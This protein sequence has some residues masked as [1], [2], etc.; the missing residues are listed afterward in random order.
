MI[1]DILAPVVPVF[2]CKETVRRLWDYLDRELAP[3]DMA[4]I[5]SHLAQC[6]KC[7][8]HF[9]FERQFLAAV[10]AARSQHT[11][12]DALRARVRAT[13][14]LAPSKKDDGAHG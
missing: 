9:A 2:D 13:L 7:P 12:P 5:D 6:D 3:A 4:A 10:K 11:A 8:Q 14:G 1:T